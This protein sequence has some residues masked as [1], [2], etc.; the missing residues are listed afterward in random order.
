MKNIFPFQPANNTS[1]ASWLTKRLKGSLDHVVSVVP[2]GFDAYVRIYHPA[3]LHMEGSRTSLSWKDVAQA[4]GRATHREM[5]WHGIANGHPLLDSQGFPLAYEGEGTPSESFKLPAMGTLPPE[6]ITPL[7][8]ILV[9]HTDAKKYWF[10]VWEGFGYLTDVARSAPVFE[11]PARRFHLFYA[12]LEALEQS[13]SAPPFN[14]DVFHQTANL[15][16][17]DDQAWCVATEIDFMSTYVGATEEAAEEIIKHSVFEAERVEPMDSV[18][19]DSV[20]VK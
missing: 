19:I 18:S 10:A 2:K 7:R 20:N 1:S 12:P 4:S 6:L 13:F 5:Q 15:W 3:W 9:K 11:I 16:W 14:D 17:P 8:H